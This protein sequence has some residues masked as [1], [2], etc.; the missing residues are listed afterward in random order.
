LKCTVL[1]FSVAFGKYGTCSLTF[2]EVAC[3][4]VFGKWMVRVS[5]LKKERMKQ[6]GRAITRLNWRLYNSYKISNKEK[7]VMPRACGINWRKEECL[8]Y[9]RSC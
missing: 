8:Y 3:F 5:F 7:K 6:G 4:R 2:K 1:V 9:L